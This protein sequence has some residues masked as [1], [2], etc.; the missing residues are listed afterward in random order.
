MNRMLK[1]STLIT[2]ILGFSSFALADT[3][4]DKLELIRQAR[5]QDLEASK[6]DQ[7]K[8]LSDS[9]AA[10]ANV[11]EV[12]NRIPS[13]GETEGLT[14]DA[15][16]LWT[17]SDP[18][19]NLK[20]IFK[21]NST[22][23]ATYSSFLPPG[24]GPSGLEL[25]DAYLWNVDFLDDHIYKLTKTGSIV[26]GIDIHPPSGSSQLN[27]GIAWDGTGFWVTDWYSDSIYK[28]SPG[29]GDTITSFLSP[30]SGKPYAY[31]L[32]WDGI[33]LWVSYSE[34]IY[35]IDPNTGNILIACTDLDFK[36]GKAYG[37]TWDGEYLWGGSWVSNEIIKISVPPSRYQPQPPQPEINLS[38]II[39][40][41]LSG[42]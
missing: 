39:F 1:T 20:K 23:G 26:G 17:S 31:G 11:C 40:L 37:L 3:H 30:L 2:L 12:I 14:K 6:L 15:G 21:I 24:E 13:P 9:L 35:K 41:L 5:Q 32:A 10:S 34:G 42:N 8:T 33:D 28:I 29:S 4:I 7:L 36:Y 16:N 25:V 18:Y 27:S 19:P 22:T 38:A